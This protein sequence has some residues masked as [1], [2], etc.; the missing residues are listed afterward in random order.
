VTID[1]Y[2]DDLFA[3][4]RH[5][6][7]RVEQLEAQLGQRP[8]ITSASAGWILRNMTAPATPPS[9]DVHIYAV[10]GQMWARSTLGDVPL[11]AQGVAD[12]VAPITATDA[13]A[14][15]NSTAQTLINTLKTTVNS[16]LVNLKLSG[17]MDSS[18]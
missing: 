1:R 16:T 6:T 17:Q 7:A 14:S 12:Y 2:P 8:A 13:G 5:L 4:I 11:L 9:G 10:S 15:Y 18:P 3:Q